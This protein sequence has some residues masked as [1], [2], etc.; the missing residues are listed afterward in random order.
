MAPSFSDW[1]GTLVNHESLET[2]TDWR[3]FV[4]CLSEDGTCAALLHGPLNSSGRYDWNVAKATA[5][6]VDIGR[7]AA[8]HRDYFHGPCQLEVFAFLMNRYHKQRRRSTQPMR[9][10][11][12][13][14]L[15]AGD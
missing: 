11:L 7:P 14:E 1:T 10:A 8:E 12:P 4:W 13:F 15:T 6:D 5:M 3:G 2:F 9:P